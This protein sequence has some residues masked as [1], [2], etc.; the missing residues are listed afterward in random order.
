MVFVFVLLTSLFYMILSRSIHGAANGIILFFFYGRV[1]S[2]CVYLPHLLYPFI[3]QRTFRLPTC[4]SY[5]KQCCYEHQGALFELWLSPNI[6]PGV[7]LQGHMAILAF[8]WGTSILFSTIEALQLLSEVREHDIEESRLWNEASR[9]VSQLCHLLALRLE[10]VSLL[11]VPQF[12]RGYSGHSSKPSLN[13]GVNVKGLVHW[14]K[15]KKMKVC[16]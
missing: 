4:L 1:I 8:F 15:K 12:P 5:C 6:C 9:F 2:H 3:C 7:G 13:W 11:S 10:Q 16:Y 14:W